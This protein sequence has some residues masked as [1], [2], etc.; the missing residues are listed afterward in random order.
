MIVSHREQVARGI[1]TGNNDDIFAVGVAIVVVIGTRYIVDLCA[2]YCVLGSVD[3][4]LVGVV[5]AMNLRDRCLQGVIGA[6]RPLGLDVGDGH[7]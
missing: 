7:A 1:G 6:V 4:L 5:R 2:K 3:V